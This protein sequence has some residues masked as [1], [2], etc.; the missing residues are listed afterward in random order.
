MTMGIVVRGSECL[1][2]DGMEQRIT[3]MS[4]LRQQKTDRHQPNG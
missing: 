3:E 2:T 1:T 4:E